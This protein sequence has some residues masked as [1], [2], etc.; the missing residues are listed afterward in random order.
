MCWQY[1]IVCFLDVGVFPILSSIIGINPP[2]GYV[3]V[4]SPG[5]A[6]YHM[7]MGAVA[8]VSA[9]TRTVEKQTAMNQ[10]PPSISPVIPPPQPINTPEQFRKTPP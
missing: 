10:G 8:G 3:L 2:I 7:A 4:N 9:W 6:T 5:A 1:A